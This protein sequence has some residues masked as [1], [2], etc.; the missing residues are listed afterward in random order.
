MFR[1]IV[2]GTDGREKGRNAVSLAHEL[3]SATG[4]RLLLVAVH[5]HGEGNP[6]ELVR[7]LRAL[8][9]ELAPEALALTVANPS[10]AAALRAVAEEQD[11]D[12]IV[13]GASARNR[14][15]RLVEGEPGTRVL[16]AATCAVALVPDDA[17]LPWQPARLGVHRDGS[18][19]C[20]VALDLADRLARSTGARV[21]RLDDD[22][23][24]TGVDLVVLG[25][26]DAG[27]VRRVLVGAARSVLVPPREPS[28]PAAAEAQAST[29]RT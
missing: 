24:A 25:S 13:V 6:G 14:L 12:L 19:E 4:A 11:A 29:A 16:R 27:D 18:A 7:R 5:E 8:R 3:A 10:P 23:D 9:N 1:T 17:P 21:A 2:A 15:R 26:R 20:L 28:A 22:A